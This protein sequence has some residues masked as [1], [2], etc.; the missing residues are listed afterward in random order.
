MKDI[1][2]LCDDPWHPAEVV[3]RGFGAVKTDAYAF[4]FVCDAKDI[5]YPEM[6]E[7]YA[8][9]V[10][11]KGDVLTGANTAAWF[12]DGVTE[13]GVKE[14]EAYVRAGH[15]FLSIHSG[16]T[17]KKDSP[18]GSFVGNI[19]IGHPPRC[20]ITVEITGGHPVVKG[21]GNFSIRDE[22]YALECIAKDA[23]E[24]FRTKSETGGDQL[25]GYVREI[26]KGRLCV[27]TPG[28]ILAVWEHP[29]YQ[30]LILNALDWCCGSSVTGSGQ[31]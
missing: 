19:F 12:E 28:H 17:A 13:A 5:L 2:V 14:L 29:A 25:G 6:L 4:D 1:L 3:K 7:R 15:G 9:I 27:M 21:V 8:A 30:K 23:A 20:S 31:E 18:Y 22:H 16:N 24:L 11:C 26:G 10:N